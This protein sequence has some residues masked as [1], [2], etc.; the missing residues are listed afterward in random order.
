MADEGGRKKGR[1][2]DVDYVRLSEEGR[3]TFLDIKDKYLS[4]E[5]C[6]GLNTDHLDFF[7]LIDDKLGSDSQY[8]VRLSAGDASRTLVGWYTA[9]I[10]H[11]RQGSK[12]RGNQGGQGEG[13]ADT[14]MRPFSDFSAL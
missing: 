13:G 11:F 8:V 3:I 10:R 9:P 7:T 1:P 4:E 5:G 14:R 2:A 12:A 6:L